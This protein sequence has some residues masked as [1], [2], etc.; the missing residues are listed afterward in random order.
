MATATISNVD[1]RLALA[2]AAIGDGDYAS[3]RD[4]VL[5]AE[6]LL[7]GIPDT[8]KDGHSIRFREARTMRL[9]QLID[10]RAAANAGIQRVNIEYVRPS[11]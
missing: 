8:E 3:A 1:A 2:D 4:Y 10:R 11:E 5:Q 9:S 6:T 7:A